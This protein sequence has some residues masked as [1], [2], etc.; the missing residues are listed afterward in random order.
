[1]KEHYA[2]CG[3]CSQLGAKNIPKF[4]IT[5]C[6]KIRENNPIEFL[7]ACWIRPEDVELYEKL[8][9]DIIKIAGRGQK[10][11]YLKKVTNSY[12][13][14]KS[15]RN[16]MELFYP[17]IWRKKMPYVDNKKLNDFIKYLWSKNLKKLTKMPFEYKI[18]YK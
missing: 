2:Y 4:D 5:W 16:V 11:P 13:N 9:V 12:M 6:Q 17:V 10:T 15:P 3:K 18:T 1:M 14:R 8:G 7:N